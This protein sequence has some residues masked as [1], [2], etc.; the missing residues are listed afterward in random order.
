MSGG[1]GEWESESLGPI[2]QV[3]G[4]TVDEIMA[5]RRRAAKAAQW[6]HLAKAPGFGK[7]ANITVN[8]LSIDTEIDIL[9]RTFFQF[10]CK[11]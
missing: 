1:F 3:E 9:F 11:R 2:E 7:F 10:L 5:S 8:D 6:A 4:N